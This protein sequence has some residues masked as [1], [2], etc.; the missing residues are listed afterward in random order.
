MNL[1]QSGWMNEPWLTAII[2]T[3]V[4]RGQGRVRSAC[5]ITTDDMRQDLLLDAYR[6]PSFALQ[7]NRLRNE[8]RARKLA[9]G[10]LNR[11]WHKRKR[12][13]FSKWRR[14]KQFGGFEN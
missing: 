2:E 6:D 11:A 1:K 8:G 10:F 12:A 5:V 3:V 7:L 13:Y 4:A 14:L 9:Y